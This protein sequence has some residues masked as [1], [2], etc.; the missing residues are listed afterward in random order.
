MRLLMKHSRQGSYEVLRGLLLEN[1]CHVMTCLEK[2][3][4]DKNSEL[5][6]ERLAK[7]ADFY[8]RKEMLEDILD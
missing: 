7:I 5:L 4:S 6:G 3:R 8:R 1:N 2:Y